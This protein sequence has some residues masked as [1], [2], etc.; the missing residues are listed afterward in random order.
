MK[1]YIKPKIKSRKKPFVTLFYRS[2]VYDSLN[3][4]LQETNSQLIVV[5]CTEGTVSCGSRF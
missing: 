4:L 5:I 3:E 1:K 2:R